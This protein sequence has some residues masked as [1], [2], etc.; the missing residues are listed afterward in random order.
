MKIALHDN[1][2]S[3]RGTTIALYDYAYYLREMGYDV[4]IMYDNNNKFND[5][6]VFDKFKI[7][8]VHP[9]NDK[10]DIDIIL[11]EQGCTHF[12]M[13]KG[14]KPDGVI[15]KVCINLV[16]A[17][18]G[19]ISKND[20]HGDKYFVCSKWLSNLTG[21]DYVPHMVNLP[22]IEGDFRSE[23]NI[24]KDAIVYGR[25]GGWETFDIP[26]VKQA[27][28][29]ILS[30]REDIYFIFQN[31]APFIQH[32][33]VIMIKS[34]YDLNFKVKFI[35]TCDAHLHARKVGESFG[36]TCAEFSIKNKPVITWNGSSERNHIDIL[37]EDGIYY[38][39][40]EDI[41]SIFRSFRPIKKE[42]INYHEYLPEN[43]ML[44]FKNKYLDGK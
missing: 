34:S 8:D 41:I 29:D 22:D 30:E 38:S 6:R 25:T 23:L 7:F 11:E 44:K 42:Y 13:I 35:N 14:G 28:H 18:S 43:V 31:T 21:I 37:G 24:P 4:I 15:S 40:Y 12:F 5:D 17:V 1:A 36:L 20:I 2:L 10:S 27:I 19:H 32:E 33:R 26:F 9:Y 3:L 39:N 16:M